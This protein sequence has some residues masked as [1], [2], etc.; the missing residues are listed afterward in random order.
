MSVRRIDSKDIPKILAWLKQLQ[1]ASFNWTEDRLESELLFAET[2]ILDSDGLAAFVCE[3]QLPGA[4]E[5]TALAT[6]PGRVNQGH[7]RSLLAARLRAA[8]TDS[9]VWL[10]VHEGNLG[11]VKLYRKLGFVQTGLRPKYY[12][13]GASAILFNKRL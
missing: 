5:W 3:R 11:A 6:D 10:E 13:D 1:A 9:E 7:M 8:K 4:I 2:W 12:S